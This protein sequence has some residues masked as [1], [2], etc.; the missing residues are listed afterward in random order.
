MHRFGLI[1]NCCRVADQYAES[2]PHGAP[3]WARDVCEFQTRPAPWTYQGQN[4]AGAVLM[5]MMEVAVR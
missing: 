5:A 4:A 3:S 1:E 2:E